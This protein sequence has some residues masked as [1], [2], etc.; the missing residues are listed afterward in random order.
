MN[1][2]FHESCERQRIR[3]SQRPVHRNAFVSDVPGRFDRRAQ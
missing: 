1:G 3:A 2:D